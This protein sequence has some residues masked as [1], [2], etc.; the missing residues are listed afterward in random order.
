MDELEGTSNS[1][2]IYFFE[3]FLKQYNDKDKVALHEIISN[4]KNELEDT[5]SQI[6]EDNFWGDEGGN[7]YLRLKN[8]EAD[9]W[10]IND[11]TILFYSIFFFGF[12]LR[13]RCFSFKNML[14]RRKTLN[15]LL[16]KRI[17]SSFIFQK[18]SSL[19]FKRR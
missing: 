2:F 10:K 5:S 4:I 7:F 9:F 16:I 3:L 8:S 12:Q 11:D 19:F 15:I 6:I 13:K 1:P 14:S 17:V 18:S